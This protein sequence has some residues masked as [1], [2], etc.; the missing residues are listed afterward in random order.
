[1]NHIRLSCL[2]P[3]ALLSLLLAFLLT[4]PVSAQEST[5]V[6]G[7]VPQISLDELNVRDLKI[8]MGEGWTADAEFTWPK[9]G[10]APFPTVILFHGGCSCGGMDGAFWESPS[11]AI[12]ERNFRL[13]A[14]ELGKQGIAVMRFN[15]R[16]ALNDRDTDATQEGKFFSDPFRAAADGEAVLS[17]VQAQAEADPAHIFLY[18]WSYGSQIASIIA[19]YHADVKGL[20]LQ[21]APADAYG[22]EQSIHMAVN[23][24]SPY[25]ARVADTN[26]DGKLSPEEINNQDVKH[27]PVTW[28]VGGLFDPSST[29]DKPVFASGLDSNKDGLV[30][31]QME[32]IPYLT[33]Q[34]QGYALTPPDRNEFTE[35]QAVARITMP[36]LI[37]DGQSDG[38]VA[39]SNAQ[40]L[41]QAA[42]SRGT[43]KLYPGLGHALS[44]IPEPALD[45]F[46]PMEQQ[47][48]NDI[49]AWILAQK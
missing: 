12:Q 49:A 32:L 29:A 37:I 43:L 13:L 9:T 40:T 33:A 45:I 35:E 42:G 23:V 1:M 20:I 30:D 4:L 18:G 2:L 5:P 14:S 19:T 26:Q 44:K 48:I 22:A 28:I 47:P 27:G 46:G 41:A 10:T 15:R 3:L 38:L 31:I 8:D 21:G 39:N 17:T 36:V 7:D 34:G 24:V 11:S 16:G 6:P 25:L